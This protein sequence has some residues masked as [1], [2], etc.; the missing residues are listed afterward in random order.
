MS[1]QS[2]G[3]EKHNAT[4]ITPVEADLA[5]VAT[6]TPVLEVPEGG[7]GWVCVV[8]ISI[9]NGFVWGS[10]TAHVLSCSDRR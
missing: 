3:A 7:Y 5:I 2:Q 6:P 8:S 9:I 1:I 4:Y 10:V